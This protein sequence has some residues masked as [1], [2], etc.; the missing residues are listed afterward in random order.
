MIHLNQHYTTSLKAMLRTPSYPIS[1]QLD[2]AAI[3]KAFEEPLAREAL[4]LAS[5]N[6]YN[7]WKNGIL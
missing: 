3:F 7:K 2:E 5:P 1:E 4:F 6:L